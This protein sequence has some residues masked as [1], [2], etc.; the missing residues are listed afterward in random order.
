MPMIGPYR[1]IGELGTGGMGVVHLALDRGGRA[2]ALKQLRAH[3]L[4]DDEAR[5]RLERE[6]AT[7]SRITDPRVAPIIDADLDAQPPYLVTR[8]IPGPSL[9]DIVQDRGALSGPDLLRLARGLAHALEAIHDAGVVHRDVKPSNVLFDDEGDPVL[10]DF[11]IAHLPDDVRI[12]LTGLVMGTPGYL[13]PEVVNGAPVTAATD[14]WGWAATLAFAASADAP[15]GHG[16]MEEVLARVRSGRFDLS[17]V[18]PHLAPLLASALAVEG[19][20]RPRAAAVL[21]ALERYADGQDATVPMPTSGT[22]LAIPPQEATQ[23]M[24]SGGV[25]PTAGATPAAGR[26]PA[27]RAG[28]ASSPAGR[29]TQRGPEP[30]EWASS[31][32]S[33]RLLEPVPHAPESD[34]PYVDPPARPDRTSG[35]IAALALFLVAVAPGWPGV[36]VL[37][38]ALVRWAAASSDRIVTSLLQRRQVRGARPSDFAVVTM[39]TPWYVLVGAVASIIALILPVLVGVAL[40]FC[41]ALVIELVGGGS[42]QPD[43]PLPIAVGMAAAL[44]MGW[45]GPGGASLRRGTRSMVRGLVPMGVVRS[46]L[47]A[48]LL[49]LAAVALMWMMLHDGSTVSWWPLSESPWAR[50][51]AG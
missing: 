47:V 9:E 5:A 40:T 36:A 20:R 49:V 16:R 43:R 34:R 39:R 50:F 2:V 41:A 15:F 29:S 4:D 23:P 14:W 45:V 33:P 28:G 18:D 44:I 17:G 32:A 11:G 27:G 48:V 25:T 35:T 42:A 24:P 7:L 51:A 38:A 8:F 13:S 37:I 6:V 31:P 3:V 22:T 26:A 46:S 19:S 1:L 21:A 30:P 12:T 10:I